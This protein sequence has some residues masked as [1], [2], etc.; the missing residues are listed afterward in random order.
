ML[1]AQRQDRID[2]DAKYRPKIIIITSLQKCTTNI[3]VSELKNKCYFLVIS[4]LKYNKKMRHNN[5]Y[6][7][8]PFESN[9]FVFF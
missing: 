4:M 7:I 2:K 9:L 8:I 3:N 6:I 5:V 1:I